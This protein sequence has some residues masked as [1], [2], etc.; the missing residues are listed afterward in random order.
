M[1]LLLASVYD[2]KEREGDR[3]G[4]MRK[5]KNNLLLCRNGL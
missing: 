3:E 2:T 5:V 4:H 1:E